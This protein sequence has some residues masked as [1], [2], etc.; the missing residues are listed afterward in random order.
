MRIN[1][2]IVVCCKNMTYLLQIFLAINRD[3]SIFE[4][5]VAEG[6]MNALDDFGSDQ[7]QLVVKEYYALGYQ[8]LWTVPEELGERQPLFCDQT[9]TWFMFYGRIDN[10]SE[11]FKKL[12]VAEDAQSDASLMMRY[13]Q[14]FGE[15]ELALVVGPFV[16]VAYDVDTGKVFA[17]RDGMGGRNLVYRI[18][19]KHILIA[20]YEMAL[21]A[22]PSVEYRFNHARIA[23]VI[24]RLIEDVLSSPIAG[25]TPLEPGQMICVERSLDSKPS[26]NYFYQF[27]GST[28]VVLRSKLLN[29]VHV[30]L[31]L[32]VQCSVVVLILCQC[33]Y[34]LRR[35]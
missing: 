20:T 24:A 32:L 18:T 19:N 16:F 23:R 21:V 26:S 12:N 1:L 3:K 13:Y 11:V 4:Q 35:L 25:L 30:Q 15:S 31:A 22:H 17:A 27:D 10:R 14:S 34:C 6:M 28:R 5:H 7:N 33:P 2:R 8:S 29:A 9:N